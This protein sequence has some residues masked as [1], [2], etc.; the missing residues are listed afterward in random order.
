[1]TLVIFDFDGVIVDSEKEKFEVTRAILK[2]YNCLLTDTDFN[3]FIGRKRSEFLEQRCPGINIPEVMRQI[4]EQDKYLCFDLIA[5]VRDVLLLL[6][7]MHA[8]IC[9]ATGS[10]RSTVE[11]VLSRHEIYQYFDLL[12]T[13]TEVKESKPDPAA[14][15]KAMDAFRDN[16][17][18]IVEDSPAGLQ[19]AKKTGA[20]VIAFGTDNGQ[21]DYSVFSHD[22]L[23][24]LFTGKIH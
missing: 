13:G 8:K 6:K 24:E 5:G 1:M 20:T 17:V 2:E 19:A 16:D 23:M 15:R 18:Y 11:M 14:F 7:R 9:V 4:H 21:A 3:E 22:E 10:E 12:V